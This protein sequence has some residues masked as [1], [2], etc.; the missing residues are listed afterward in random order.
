M[1]TT[2]G[3]LVLVAVL[4]AVP[5]AAQTI[6]P[7][8]GEYRGSA[9]GMYELRNDGDAPLAVMIEP[10]SFTINADGQVEFA[11]L[12][13]GVVL[14]LPT[15][16]F[17]IPAGQS[18][19]VFYKLKSKQLPA[20]FGIINTLTKA[21]PASG[22]LRINFVLPHM[23]Y[24]YQKKKLGKKDVA[25]RILPGKEPG[26][27]VLELENLSDKLSRVSAVEPIG[28]GTPLPGFP[29]F[30]RQVRRIVLKPM[31]QAALRVRFQ[32]GLK[33]EVRSSL[34]NR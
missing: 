29:F 19:Y 17:T 30:P 11:P 28:G 14:Q 8:I 21:A 12:D 5:G 6:L 24:V 31:Q 18:H 23:V 16:S 20:W 4:R 22:G 9:S 10:R 2:C 13:P 34:E 3:L 26:E 33:M 15:T 25:G 1:K 7:P 32:D 27:Q